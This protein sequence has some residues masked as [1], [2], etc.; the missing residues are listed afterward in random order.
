MADQCDGVPSI[1]SSENSGE[2]LKSASNSCYKM[3]DQCDG[4]PLI[5]ISQNTREILKPASNSPNSVTSNFVYK[6]EKPYQNLN[7]RC[8]TFKDWP[9]HHFIKPFHLAKAGFYYTGLSDTVQ[10]YECKIRLKDFELDDIPMQ[11]H[12]KWSPKCAHVREFFKLH[13]SL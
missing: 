9:L 12:S 5:S 7:S 8:E 11:E 10:C 6:E 1:L 4:V 3:P 2:V 13:N